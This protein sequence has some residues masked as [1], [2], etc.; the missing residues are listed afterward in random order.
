MDNK[1]YP[2]GIQ[3]FEK[4]RK[5]GYAYVDKT[6]LAFQLAK[7]GS[8]FFLNRPRRFGKSLLISTLE[9]YF[10]GKRELFEG[11][12]LAQLEK[13]WVKRPVLH[14]DFSIAKYDASDSLDKMLNARLSSW[15]ALYGANSAETT[16]ALR[17]AGIIK[18]AE[19][20]EGHRVA[21]L[22]DEYDKPLLQAAINEDLH[23][24]YLSTLQP[25]YG[26][27]KTMD[28]CIKFALLTGVT[29]FTRVCM[30]DYLNN[31]NDISMDRRYASLCGFNDEELHRHFN[32]SIGLLA[33]DQAKTV[34]ETSRLLAENYGG[35][36]F[37]ED[38]E[39]IYN[40]FSLLNAF[41]K[42]KFGSYWNGLDT[43][44]YLV[45]LLKR[46]HYELDRM[47]HVETDADTLNSICTE[48][49]PIPLIFQSGYLT[50]QNLDKEFGLY[51]LGFTNR[52]A[53]EGLVRLLMPFY[54]R[55]NK[56]EAPSELHRLVR[57]IERGQTGAT[58]KR[59]Q[60]FFDGAPYRTV[61]D[62]Q[63]YYRNVLFILF[64][65]IG[66]SMKM[67]YH[68][69][70]T[71]V[72]VVLQTAEYIYLIT[73]KLDGSAEEALL[74]IEEKQS[75]VPFTSDPRQLFKIGVSFNNK[76]RSIGRWVVE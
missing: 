30:S 18:R 54:V 36:H 41:S 58:L 8:Y 3:N 11:L 31:L 45:E 27:L 33:E 25:F 34:E 53:E 20:Q 67:E 39:A 48:D 43:P 7:S 28:G 9:A 60:S 71:S 52:E 69:A 61:V 40:P 32:D 4:I 21:I 47:G 66:F 59:L 74:Q 72:D 6:A 73:F 62:Q 64:K 70:D 12:A 68:A 50:I 26:V 42:M 15:E 44:A 37:V 55:F 5:D 56:V 10:L 17:F 1:I 2:V 49:H 35:Y 65:L 14:L 16:F 46:N 38:S 29:K 23:R 22:I 19:E 57:E 24:R 75:A 63:L 76:T 13:V 51:H